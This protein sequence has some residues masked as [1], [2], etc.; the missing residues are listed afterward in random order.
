MVY[1]DYLF[2]IFI[3][4]SQRNTL[5]PSLQQL[6]IQ[7]G[8]VGT[9]TGNKPILLP[10][11]TSGR[12]PRKYLEYIFIFELLSNIRRMASSGMLRLVDLVRTDFSEELS[13]SFF[14][15]T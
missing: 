3:F 10:S 4:L 5:P 13:A 11:P 6:I 12:M 9:L 2:E 14:R 7:R 15:L 8:A 1:S